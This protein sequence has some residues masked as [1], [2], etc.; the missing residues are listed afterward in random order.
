MKSFEHLWPRDPA[1]SLRSLASQYQRLVMPSIRD[2]PLGLVS[3][4]SIT[5][6]QDQAELS[7]SLKT[8]LTNALRPPPS[9]PLVRVPYYSHQL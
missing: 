4:N 6:Q 5:A 2:L 9:Q 8:P 1:G 3:W 7:A